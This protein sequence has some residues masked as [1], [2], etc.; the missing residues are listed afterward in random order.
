MQSTLAESTNVK[1]MSINL[2]IDSE[3]ALRYG[4]GGNG[5]GVDTESDGP[6]SDDAGVARLRMAAS[7]DS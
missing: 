4:G 7:Q 5:L 6:A 1:N 2:M 3:S